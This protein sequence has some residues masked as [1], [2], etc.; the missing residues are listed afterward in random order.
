[1]QRRLRRPRRVARRVAK[2]A[3]GEAAVWKI[4]FLVVDRKG[5]VM[6]WFGDLGKVVKRMPRLMTLRRNG[7]SEILG[8]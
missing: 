7:L 4:C 8:T 3:G 6:P 5:A 1:M 2:E